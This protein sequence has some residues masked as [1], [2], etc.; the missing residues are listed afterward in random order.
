MNMKQIIR[1]VI[2]FLIGLIT[3]SIGFYFYFSL[4]GQEQEIKKLSPLN[5]TG[6]EEA[7]ITA[8][9]GEVY[10]LRDDT[11]LAAEIGEPLYAGDII[12]VVDESFCQIQFANIAAAKI[13]SNSIVKLKKLLN[14][15]NSADI[16]TEILTGSMLYRVNK[17]SEGEKLEVKS[18]DRIFSVRGTTFFIDRNSEGTYLAVDEGIVAVSE[19]GSTNDSVN[20]TAGNEIYIETDSEAE[21]LTEITQKSKSIIDAAVNLNLLNFEAEENLLIKTAVKTIPGDAQIYVNGVLTGRGNY[22]GLFH[23]EEDVTFLIRK[24]GYMDKVLSVSAVSNLE[25]TVRL[26]PERNTTETLNNELNRST[27]DNNMEN[28]A[29]IIE[30]LKNDLASRNER[31]TEIEVLIVEIKEKNS[32]LESDKSSLETKNRRMNNQILNLERQKEDLSSEITELERKLTESIGREN[33]LRDV[34]KQIQDISTSD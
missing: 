30:Q 11:I 17:L 16:K 6:N 12:K 14:M 4:T 18:E 20:A 25:Y 13:R 23:K 31:L 27:E 10:I 24:R 3:A 9:S 21:Y 29:A 2:I 34:I 32:Q 28:S 5:L 19:K 1:P 7:F 26:E 22:S 15:D 8:L 33:K